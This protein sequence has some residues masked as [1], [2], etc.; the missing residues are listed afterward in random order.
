MRS[1]LLAVLAAYLIAA[2][3]SILAFVNKRRS[4][5]RVAEWSTVVGFI[6]HTIA[7]IADWVIDGHYPV[8]SLRE[9]L[10]FLAWALVALYS[11]VLYRY[12]TQAVGAFTM[13]LIS[14]L[15]F[16]ALV[17]GA[18]T[19]G[20][21]ASFSATWLFPIHTTLLIFAYAAFF[22]VF[23][24]SV[25][26]LLQERELKLKTFSAIFHRLPSLTTVN[27]LATYAA[28]FG[29]TLLTLGIATGMIWSRARS[30]Q[31]WHN[32]PKEIFAVLTWLLYFFL[33]IYRS[34]ANWRGRRA[35]WLGVVGF[36]LVLC[37]FFGA[38]LLGG[39]HVFG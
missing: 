26:Y 31:L 23:M 22:I 2:I 35:A 8:F 28:A 14:V 30:G 10:S 5:Q 4:L 27:E 16:I 20:A 17:L 6:L 15:T 39:Y 38:P 18:D 37:T 33:I 1:L 9:T 29:L 21:P 19:T 7:L 3:H 11:V 36:V 24:A 25:M 12:R 34:S 13:P 32:D